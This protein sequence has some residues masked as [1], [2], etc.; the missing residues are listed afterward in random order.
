VFIAETLAAR[1]SQQANVIVR[2]R[3][4]PVDAEASSRLV[5]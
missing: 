3:D 1:L 2:H 5:K 4:A